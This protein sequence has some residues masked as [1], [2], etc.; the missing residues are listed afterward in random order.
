MEESCLRKYRDIIEKISEFS[1][2]HLVDKCL[3]QAEADFTSGKFKTFREALENSYRLCKAE[4]EE[5]GKT[6]EVE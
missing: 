1:S 2:I 3:K 4:P 5:A 6:D